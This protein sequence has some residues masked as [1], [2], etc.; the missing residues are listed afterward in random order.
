MSSCASYVSR[1]HDVIIDVTRSRS[2]QIGYCYISIKISAGRQS[3]TQNIGI[4]H[5][6]IVGVFNF[7]YLPMQSLLWPQNGGHYEKIKILNIASTWPQTCK[8]RSS[9]Y[10]KKYFLWW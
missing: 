7:R 4:A 2:R 6:Y 9:L 1:T 8:G 3:K 5:G 10:Q